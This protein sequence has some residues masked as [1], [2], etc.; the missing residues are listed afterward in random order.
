M[1]CILFQRARP[2]RTLLDYVGQDY[3]Y[4]EYEITSAKGSYIFSELMY[5]FAII[6]LFCYL[7]LHIFLSIVSHV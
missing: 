3:E 2:I 7:F 5:N 4:K 1:S 6:F